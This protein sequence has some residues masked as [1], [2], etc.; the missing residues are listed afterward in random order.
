VITVNR[1]ELIAYLL[2]QMPEEQRVALEDRWMEDPD[3]HQQLRSL[4]AE[5]LDAYV[6][7]DVSANDRTSIE[8]FLLTSDSQRRKLEFARALQIAVSTPHPSARPWGMLAAVAACLVLGAAVWWMA[9]QNL[10][11]RRELISRSVETRAP[12]GSLYS[13]LL[14]PETTRGALEPKLIQ[15]PHTTEVMR[16]E[17][18]LDPGDENQSYAVELS[19]AGNRVWEEEPIHSEPR[20]SRFVVPVW[21]STREL[22]PGQ[23]QIKLS[24]GGKAIEYYYFRTAPEV[25]ALPAR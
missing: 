5:L 18:E 24:V 19:M 15:P 12:A 11:L 25:N 10:A 7:G 8:S 9:W 22:K 1:D 4:E 16:L 13:A 21:I 17:L 2:H 20:G 3:L 14:R 23:Y 6:R